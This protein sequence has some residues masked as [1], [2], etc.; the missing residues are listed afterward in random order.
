MFAGSIIRPDAGSGKLKQV[1][2]RIPEIQT[3]TA[4][5]PLNFRFNFDSTLAQSRSPSLEGIRRNGKGEVASTA[6]VMRRDDA[7]TNDDRFIRPAMSKEQ[8]YIRT[9]PQSTE[10][11]VAHHS[12]KIEQG[13]IEVTRAIDLGDVDASLDDSRHPQVR[14]LDWFHHFQF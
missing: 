11:L 8:E 4:S 12:V 3:G 14:T 9:S 10:A 5:L 2:I 7:S 1:G 13:L 6:C